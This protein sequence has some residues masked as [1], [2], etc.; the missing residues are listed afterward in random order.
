MQ[1]QI[2]QLRVLIVDDNPHML[3]IVKTILRGFGVNRVREARDGQRAL[4][5]LADEEI[6]LMVVDYQMG[7]MDGVELIRRIRSEDN[8][9]RRFM[10]IIMLTAHAERSRVLAARDAGA[11]E[12]C[13]KPVTAQDLWRKIYECACNPRPF[14][15]VNEYFGPCRRRKQAGFPGLERRDES[16][17]DDAPAPNGPRRTPS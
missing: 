12:F 10:P 2:G 5:I 16:P 15:R 4:E 11:T 17:S 9:R 3:N 13:C 6:D 1:A 14:V 8:A 7:D